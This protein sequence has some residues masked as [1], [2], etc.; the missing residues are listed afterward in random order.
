MSLA[1]LR[2]A[3]AHASICSQVEHCSGQKCNPEPAYV[4]VTQHMPHE[5]F[6]K[7]QAPVLLCVYLKP[8]DQKGEQVLCKEDWDRVGL[9]GST[10]H[11]ARPYLLKPSVV[12]ASTDIY[13]YRYT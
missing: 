4:S 11:L 9:E 12:K 10:K 6:Y 3:A 8:H 13:K 1:V 5:I 7:R 2:S